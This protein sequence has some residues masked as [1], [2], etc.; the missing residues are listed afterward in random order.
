MQATPP[1]P[2]GELRVYSDFLQIQGD[3]GNLGFSDLVCPGGVAW[4]ADN[5][6]AVASLPGPLSYY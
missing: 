3:E 5:L 4:H 2:G 6:S 1:V